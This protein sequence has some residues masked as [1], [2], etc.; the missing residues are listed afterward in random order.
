MAANEFVDMATSGADRT[1][2]RLAAVPGIRRA[3]T[4]KLEQFMLSRFLDAETCAGLI[5]QIDRDVRPSTIADPNGDEAF[6]TST[7]CDLDHRDPLVIAVNNRLHDLTGIPLAY[8]E[9]M[10]G[11]RYDVGQ[12]FK[13]HTD[14]FDPHGADWE[15]YCA[16]PGQ[17]SWTLMIY[18]NEPGAGGA[19]RFLATGKLHQPETRQAARVEQCPPRRHRQPRHAPPRDEGAQGAQVYHH[20]MV[21][22]TALAVG[23]GGVGVD[24]PPLDGGRIRSLIA[25]RL[26][27]V[28]WGD[29]ASLHR[30]F[31][32]ERSH[33]C[34]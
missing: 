33:R 18:L 11:Q 7:T 21:P 10:Q 9:P 1:A 2:A 24:S 34:D 28:G 8:G 27:E 19:T 15:T 13:A 16:I 20:Q 4:P 26:G 12:E 31:R 14:Y 23:G 32:P 6:R 22:R 29:G 3:P 30:G 17:R 25:K 5:A